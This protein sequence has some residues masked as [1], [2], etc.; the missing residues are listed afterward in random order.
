MPTEPMQVLPQTELRPYIL[1][2]LVINI[3]SFQYLRSIVLALWFIILDSD[4]PAW[5]KGNFT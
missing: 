5:L 3:N 4:P 2:S 1:N